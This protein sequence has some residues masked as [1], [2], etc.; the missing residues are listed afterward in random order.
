MCEIIRKFLAR[1]EVEQA[2]AAPLDRRRAM[3]MTLSTHIFTELSIKVDRI[4]NGL[5]RSEWT[6]PR[7]AGA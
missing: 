1:S 3:K 5:V 7:F 4:E 2:A 6:S